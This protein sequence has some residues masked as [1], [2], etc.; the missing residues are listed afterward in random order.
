MPV[1]LVHVIRLN[2]AHNYVLRT[3]MRQINSKLSEGKANEI[4]HSCKML[5][6]AKIK[7]YG[8][9]NVSCPYRTRGINSFYHF[10]SFTK[11]K[12][13]PTL[14]VQCPETLAYELPRPGLYIVM[15][16]PEQ[17]LLDG[18]GNGRWFIILKRKFEL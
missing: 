2:S 3:R 5:H 11:F 14:A 6:P 16:Y 10:I 12:T 13:G 1:K 18:V 4:K 17:K 9:C 15:R 8:N 7:C